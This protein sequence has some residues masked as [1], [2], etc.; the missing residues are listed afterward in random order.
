[1]GPVIIFIV[2]ALLVP[3]AL[4]Q[5]A[6][7]QPTNSIIL[8]IYVED[9]GQALLIGQV[10]NPGFLDNLP[11]YSYDD[12]TGQL[13]GK[14]DSLTS[15]EGANWKLKFGI[16]GNLEAFA[17]SFYLPPDAS[18]TNLELSGDLAYAI[19]TED[20]YLVVSVYGFMVSNPAITIDYQ[21]SLALSSGER[22]TLA[23]SLI[24]LAAFATFLVS[25]KRSP[26]TIPA[27]ETP[28]PEKPLAA[29]PSLQRVLGILS[30]RERAIVKV[31]LENGGTATQAKIR[32][33][34]GIPKSS[35]TGIVNGLRRRNVIEKRRYG[36]TNKIELSSAFL[37]ENKGVETPI[38]Q[39]VR[40]RKYASFRSRCSRGDVK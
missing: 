18:I 37:S 38:P 26:Q 17:A 39:N 13:I 12:D 2:L 23:Y 5:G 40:D 19:G 24:L 21:R 29:N 6:E 25:R 4:G 32:W 20:E 34:T 8:D 27:A 28:G 22:P 14:T 10:S 1:M 33:E 31:L 9:S 35:L 15:K 3:S 11:D 16:T 30:E 36:R 7:A